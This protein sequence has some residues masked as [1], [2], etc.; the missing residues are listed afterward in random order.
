MSWGWGF[1]T[2]PRKLARKVIA[3]R[4]EPVLATQ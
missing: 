1:L 2:S 4:R 3:S